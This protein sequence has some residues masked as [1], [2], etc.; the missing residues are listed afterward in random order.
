MKKLQI[1]PDKPMYEFTDAATNMELM[2]TAKQSKANPKVQQ[3]SG[4]SKSSV[5]ESSSVV[6]SFCAE[7]GHEENRCPYKREESGDEED[8]GDEY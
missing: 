8:E 7:A 4:S 1:D 6:C 5:S 3:K 2:D